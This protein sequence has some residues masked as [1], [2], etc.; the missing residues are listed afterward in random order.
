MGCFPDDSYLAKFLLGFPSV[1]LLT[2]SLSVRKNEEFYERL[3]TRMFLLG[4]KMSFESES[5]V[6]K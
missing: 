1:L 5:L 4:Y 6:I 2:F 3:L